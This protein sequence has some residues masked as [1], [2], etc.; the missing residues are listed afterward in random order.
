MST[1]VRSSASVLLS[2]AQ[3][4]ST[5]DPFASTGKTAEPAQATA[6]GAAVDAV[7]ES[8]AVLV[9]PET[10]APSDSAAVVVGMMIATT[11]AAAITE[12]KA[13]ETTERSLAETI[14]SATLPP[15]P[16][17]WPP[18]KLSL[19]LQGGGTFSAF[20]WGVLDRLL[21]EP[22]CDFDTIS[23]ASA[24]AV[25]AALLASGLAKGGRDEARSRLGLFWTRLMDEASFRSLMVIGAFSPASSS[26]CF[27]PGLRGGRADPLDLDPLRDILLETIDFEAVQSAAA[28]RLLVSATRVRDGSPQ[29][30]RNAGIT[31]DVL[32]ASTCPAQLNAAVDIG[33]D[34]YW[35]G[36]YSANPPLVQ[37]AHES[38]AADLL[39][40]QV[41]PARN[42]Y[43]PVTSA[44]IDRRLD[45]IAANAVLNAELAALEW[46]R[47]DG[48]H[49]PRV[50]QLSAEEAIEAL[51]Q[52]DATDLG[53]DFIETLH[54]R[55]R[56]AADRWLRKAPLGTMP[57]IV[58]ERPVATG[59]QVREVAPA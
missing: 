56:E 27:G 45:Q 40:V 16:R 57:A 33:D 9:T 4:W 39:V 12:P 5:D 3:I 53:S 51:A 28:P 41:T 23:G 44:A 49:P 54:Q 52:R 13:A 2:A 10:S 36:S 18:R 1:P 19:A 35:D 58:D 17:I 30:F 31:P 59:E 29:I 25:N 42:G 38:S 6:T 21:E 48:L 8:P 26:V 46:A 34:A 32:L 14:A 22:N 50:H 11:S 24:G 55:G 7:A 20:T 15:P 37:I 43:V 47:S